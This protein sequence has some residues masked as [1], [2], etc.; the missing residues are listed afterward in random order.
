[1]DDVVRELQAAETKRTTVDPTLPARLAMDHVAV[2]RF[3]D[4]LARESS[5]GLETGVTLGLVGA[6]I[7]A[8]VGMLTS[9]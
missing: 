3:F 7:A 4:G 8:V 2:D 1:V 9:D 5:G 6:G